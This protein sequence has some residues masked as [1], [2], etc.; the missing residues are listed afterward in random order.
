MDLSSYVLAR[1]LPQNRIRFQ[2]ALEALAED[3]DPSFPLAD[4]NDLL[5]QLS[6]A[7]LRDTTADA[8]VSGLT[9]FHACYVA[10]MVEE[11]AHRGDVRPPPWVKRVPPLEEPYFATDLPAIR[12]HLLRAS[13]VPFK[14]RN[15]FID[16]SLGARV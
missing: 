2:E 5:T 7:E 6:P 8:D 10:A 13:P 12:L 16:A 15:I 3:E 4:L 11:A 9:P 14:R 1:A